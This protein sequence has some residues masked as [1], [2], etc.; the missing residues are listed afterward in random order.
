MEAGREIAIHIEDT[1]IICERTADASRYDRPS[2]RVVGRIIHSGYTQQAE[3]SR[4]RAG[5]E[6]DLAGG[7]GRCRDSDAAQA[8]GFFYS[9]LDL[10][11]FLA[12]M[13]GCAH[14]VGCLHYDG[15][16]V[17]GPTA[18][19]GRHPKLDRF[20][21]Y[22]IPP[23]LHHWQ[24]PQPSPVLTDSISRGPSPYPTRRHMEEQ[25]AIARLKQGDIR[26]LRALVREHQVQAIRTAYLITRDRAQAEDIVQVER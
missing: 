17:A 8:V 10:F 1:V 22:A 15:C 3:S 16:Y 14:H 4:H 20:S 7:V 18:G 12:Q 5:R 9:S 11:R 23:R 25:E 6:L 2:S 26:G 13:V 21:R 19:L 24:L